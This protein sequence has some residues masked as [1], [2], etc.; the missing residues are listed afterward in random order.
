MK[1]AF[2]LVCLLIVL[3]LALAY[4]SAPGAKCSSNRQ[5]RLQVCKLGR[6]GPRS[7][8]DDICD[9][10][11]DCV[12][13]QT[14]FNQRCTRC[15]GR[16][17]CSALGS[18]EELCVVLDTD[19]DNCGTCGNSCDE[20]QSCENGVCTT[21][22]SGFDCYDYTD[23]EEMYYCCIEDGRCPGDLSPIEACDYYAACFAPLPCEDYDSNT[24]IDCCDG[25]EDCPTN[26]NRAQACRTLDRCTR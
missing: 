8:R 26:V 24:L 4:P 17:D 21:S 5:C 19:I 1:A 10:E 20:D 22:S 3:G 14:C 13:E 9:E 15:P 7:E 25:G 6:C 18:S 2:A 11:A 12:G 16:T 23:E